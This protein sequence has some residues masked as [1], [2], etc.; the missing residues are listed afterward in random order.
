MFLGK[1]AKTVKIPVR[2]VNGQVKYFY[3]GNLPKIKDGIIG[4]LI[5]PEYGIVDDLFLEISQMKYE[6]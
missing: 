6:R 4:E 3:G 1:D 5:L 2:I